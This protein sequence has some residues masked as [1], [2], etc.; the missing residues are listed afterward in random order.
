MKHIIVLFIGLVLLMGVSSCKHKSENDLALEMLE[1]VEL[2]IGRGDYKSAL[3]SITILRNRY[4]NAVEARKKALVLWDEA[5]LLQAED[6][7]A[8]CEMLLRETLQAI[9]DAPTLLE[10]NMLRN[11]R[12]SLQARY[13]AAMGVI[14]IIHAKQNGE[15]PEPLVLQREEEETDTLRT[16]EDGEQ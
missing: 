11:K 8:Q 2:S 14:K 10:Q 16:K 9:D 7:A 13:D 15:E 5:S 3:D 12:D 1:D 6:E 4:P